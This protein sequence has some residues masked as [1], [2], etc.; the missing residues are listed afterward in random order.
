M[1]FTYFNFCNTAHSF[2]SKQR[3]LI[4]DNCYDP[5]V[6]NRYREYI[7]GNH[8]K[9]IFSRDNDLSYLEEFP[10]VE[11]VIA[12]RESY[13]LNSLYLL[14]DLKMLYLN[15]TDLS[16]NYSK[17][18][19][20]V[21]QL[22]FDGDISNF[23]WLKMLKLKGVSFSNYGIKDL[24]WIKNFLSKENITFFEI[25]CSLGKFISTAG[26]ED[27]VNCKELVFDYCR[28]LKDISAIYS[29]SNLED[30][31]FSDNPKVELEDF[32][33]FPKLQKLY[34]VDSETERKRAIENLNFLDD[35]PRLK[36]FV[37]DYIILDGNVKRL[38]SLQEARLFTWKNYYNAPKRKLNY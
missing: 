15:T 3:Y 14:K 24:S 22:F 19:N 20:S 11:G 31:R 27:L 37:T 7:N 38:L 26:I 35:L 6:K 32:S 4:V 13:N 34:L 30:L 9:Y 25:T 28:K 17:L 36:S 5:Y 1:E 21:E 8:V 23:S 33:S 16:F 12:D 18:S 10:F 29:L 2:W